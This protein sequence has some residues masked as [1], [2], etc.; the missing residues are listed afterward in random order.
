MMSLGFQRFSAHEEYLAALL[1]Y[2]DN[3]TGETIARVRKCAKTADGLPTDDAHRAF[4]LG[5]E[6]DLRLPLLTEKNKR[7]WAHLLASAHQSSKY[8]DLKK[9]SPFAKALLMHFYCRNGELLCYNDDEPVGDIGTMKTGIPP[10]PVQRCLLVFRFNK[11]A[12]ECIQ[13]EPDYLLPP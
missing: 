2:L 12:P 11:R 8:G 1:R 4:S 5:K 10:D 13:L 9:K 3:P 6:L 7:E